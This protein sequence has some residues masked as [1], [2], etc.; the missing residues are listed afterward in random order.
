[1]DSPLFHN[2]FK[3]IDLSFL[4]KSYILFL[5]Q[6]GPELPTELGGERV[7]TYYNLLEALIPW[8]FFF[9]QVLLSAS[10]GCRVCTVTSW[11]GEQNF[12]R[13]WCMNVLTVWCMENSDLPFSVTE[14]WYVF[15]VVYLLEKSGIIFLTHG[16]YFWHLLN[17]RRP[18]KIWT[19]KH[20][21]PTIWDRLYVCFC[22]WFHKMV[23]SNNLEI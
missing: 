5:T 9:G 6:F 8:Y 2:R 1:M 12:L 7:L 13:S 23:F 16:L 10:S 3:K 15:L 22:C 18:W 19:V 14:M 20:T 17:W 4:R 11:E 21:C